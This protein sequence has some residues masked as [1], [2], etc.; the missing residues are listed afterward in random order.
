PL[1]RG[2]PLTVKM[3]G[4]GAT[5]DPDLYVRFGS[6]PFVHAYD[7]RP[8]VDGPNELCAL[9]VPASAHQVFVM[10]R[11]FTAGTYELQITSVPPSAAPSHCCLSSGMLGR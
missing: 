7:C 2:S 10:V 4:S 1:P 11:G 6:Q 8:F 9:T 3:G 5:G